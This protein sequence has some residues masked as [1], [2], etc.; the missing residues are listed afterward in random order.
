MPGIVL[1]ADHRLGMNRPVFARTERV[2]LR[3]QGPF[4]IEV[5]ASDGVPVVRKLPVSNPSGRVLSLRSV[6]CPRRNDLDGDGEEQVARTV[7]LANRAP[8]AEVPS[9]RCV[10]T[11]RVLRSFRL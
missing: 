4:L 11:R 10:R 2:N 6:A 5:L 8:S 1:K 3:E 9:R 7:D